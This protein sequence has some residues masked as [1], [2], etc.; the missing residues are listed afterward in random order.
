[1]KVYEGTRDG[2]GYTHVFV[3]DNTGE[4]RPLTHYAKHSPDGFEWGFTG[5]GPAELA[6][7][8]L[9]DHFGLATRGP[10]AEEIFDPQ[11]G[12][13]ARLP[14]DY[15]AFK[16]DV[17]SRFVQGKPWRLTSSQIDAWISRTKEPPS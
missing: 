12:E 11:T 5:P 3:T 7:C 8:L 1:V 14:A 4:R 13:L 17:I 2:L 16:W 10:W 6:R 15:Q 9:L